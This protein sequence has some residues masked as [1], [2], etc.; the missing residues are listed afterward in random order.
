MA[1]H[2]A[3]PSAWSKNT[4]SAAFSVVVRAMELSL[5]RQGRARQLSPADLQKS[6][7]KVTP[8]GLDTGF[9]FYDL[10][11]VVDFVG[12]KARRG[13]S[14]YVARSYPVA[15]LEQA[16]EQLRLGRPVLAGVQVSD[17]W[18]E[19]QAAQHGVLDFE[20]P[21][22][23]QGAT[24]CAI[25]SWDPRDGN[26]RVLTPWATYGDGGQLTVSPRAAKQVFL[27]GNMRSIEPVELPARLHG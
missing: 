2:P 5:E 8:P 6:L 18:W 25:V 1:G 13:S 21:R 27:T 9:M 26:V 19:P 3:R 12:V 7:E 10:I 4:A 15:T 24:V 20:R 23:F 17:D 16:V 14:R 22:Q 11:H